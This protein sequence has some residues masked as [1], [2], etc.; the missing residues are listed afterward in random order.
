MP[1]EKCF[2]KSLRVDLARSKRQKYEGSDVQVNPPDGA[3]TA[4]V[5]PSPDPGAQ[6][7]VAGQRGLL[8]VEVGGRPPTAGNR[9][10]SNLM[11]SKGVIH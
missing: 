8:R 5:P 11:A 4:M 2:S 7:L 10:E 1:S 3:L 6:L 9:E